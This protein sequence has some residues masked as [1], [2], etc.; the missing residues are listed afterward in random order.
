MKQHRIKPK[1]RLTALLTAFCLLLSVLPISSLPVLAA[2]GT[3][4]G[5]GTEESPYQIADGDDLKAF[6]DLVNGGANDAW[7]VLTADI[8]LNPGYTFNTD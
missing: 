6:R 2:N 8:D 7:A 1:R 4:E 5:D 3:L